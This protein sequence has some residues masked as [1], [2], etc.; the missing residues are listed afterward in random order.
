[1][2]GKNLKKGIIFTAIT[3]LS[4][5]IVCTG[6]YAMSLK[7]TDIKLDLKT[8]MI[9]AK[10][11]AQL[12]HEAENLLKK[13]PQTSDEAEK[14]YQEE[15]KLK[16]EFIAYANQNRRADSNIQNSKS[17]SN[18]S[19]ENLSLGIESKMTSLSNI[20][21]GAK[22]END[23]ELQNRTENLYNQ[24]KNLLETL[25]ES[26]V[27]EIYAKYIE[28][29]NSSKPSK[30][31]VVEMIKAKQEKYIEIIKK[32]EAENNFEKK[33]NAQNIYNQY[34]SLLENI[35]EENFEEIL[36]QYSDLNDSIIKNN[37]V[38]ETVK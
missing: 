8:T 17:V 28:I 6:V 3:A 26:N 31:N 16:Q 35:N 18:I 2:K 33:A 37:N 14:L 27:Q 5:G 34:N 15:L 22:L 38:K 30:E 20:L 23:V 19:K 29:E 1:M 32:A 13:N 9:T 36:S 11:K 21:L 24:Y 7:A 12:E 25:N 4:I 10:S